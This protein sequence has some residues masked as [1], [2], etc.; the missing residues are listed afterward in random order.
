MSANTSQTDNILTAHDVEKI[1]TLSRLAIDDSKASAY[2]TSLNKILSL[3]QALQRIDTTGVEPLKSPFDHAQP[4]RN[5]AV[6]EPN[7]RDD[8]QAVA[9][10]TQDGL[11]LVP[12]VIE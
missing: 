8:Y 7:R 4:L 3:M 10:A 2:A 12:R 9:P 11:Y 6:T 1:A 5:D